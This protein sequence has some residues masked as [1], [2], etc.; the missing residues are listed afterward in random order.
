MTKQ[1][2]IQ[3]SDVAPEAANALLRPHDVNIYKCFQVFGK[4]NF[5]TLT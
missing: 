5:T 2:I 4:A 3:Y 1:I